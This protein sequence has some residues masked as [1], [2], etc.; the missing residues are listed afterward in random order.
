MSEL[1]ASK[2]RETFIR[3]QEPISE[4][5]CEPEKR[6]LDVYIDNGVINL[7]KPAGPT[8]HEVVA[9]VKRILGIK[10]AGHSGTL[11]PHVTGDLPIMIGN[12]TKGVVALLKAG[13]EYVC[14]MKLHAQI[15]PAKIEQACNMFTGPIYQRPPLVS[16]I[17]RQTRIRTIYYLDVH[18]I[19]D[20]D[21][22]F[23]VGCEA[24]TYIRK[25]CHDIGEVLGPGAHMQELRRTKAGPFTADTSVTLHDLKDAWVEYQENGDES[26]IRAIIHPMESALIHLPH[27]VIRESAVDALCHGASLA[28]VGLLTVESDIEPG[29]MVAVMTQKG[30][31]VMLGIADMATI[32]M[33]NAKTGIAVTSKRVMMAPNTYP[34]GWVTKE[35]TEG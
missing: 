18:E 14:V 5:G 23:T 29:D 28:A 22:L 2:T 31:A 20:R 4:Y 25:L 16:A 35:H 19:E 17:K 11:D 33:L 13:K 3:A 21:V 8:S 27:V 34:K 32:N 30:E 10:R 26:G 9:W 12:A 24:G 6:T 7:D 1:P 15:P